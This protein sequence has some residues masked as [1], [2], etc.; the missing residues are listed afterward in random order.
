MQAAAL[1]VLKVSSGQQML[2][3]LQKQTS[4][5]AV[6]LQPAQA[7]ERQQGQGFAQQAPKLLQ[8]AEALLQPVR[9]CQMAARQA[10]PSM[11]AMQEALQDVLGQ[12]EVRAVPV[13]L[14]ACLSEHFQPLCRLLKGTN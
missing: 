4:D 13:C 12:V 3:Q 7:E 11:A 2:L 14:N 9:D 8:V 5:A 1:S 6:K 10:L